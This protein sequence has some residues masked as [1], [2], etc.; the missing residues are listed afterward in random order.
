MTAS[1][2]APTEGWRRDGV[3][4][5]PTAVEVEVTLVVVVIYEAVKCIARAGWRASELRF[6]LGRRRGPAGGYRAGRPRDS[7]GGFDSLIALL[8]L[9]LHSVLPLSVHSGLLS[10]LTF[11]IHSSHPCP[12]CALC[13]RAVCPFWFRNQRHMTHSES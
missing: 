13:V 12:Y 7:A 10:M 11:L 1:H 3:M 9:L 5:H 4:R 8:H 6:W 2:W